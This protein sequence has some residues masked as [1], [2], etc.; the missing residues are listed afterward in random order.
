MP[1]QDTS[2]NL[3][4]KLCRQSPPAHLLSQTW[5]VVSTG[6]KGRFGKAFGISAVIQ[7]ALR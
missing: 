6:R 2:E 7:P 4:Y 5:T 3:G 1:G